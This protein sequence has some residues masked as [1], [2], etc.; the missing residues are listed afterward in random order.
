MSDVV[1]KDGD[2]WDEEW[3]AAPPTR[4]RWRTALLLTLAASLV[5]LAGVEVQRHFGTAGA[6]SS[7]AGAPT[8]A[9]PGM[10]S[11]AM[12]SGAPGQDPTGA[13]PASTQ[14]IGTVVA[15]HGSVWVVKDL[16]GTRH[17]ITVT[18]DTDI[19]REQRLTGSAVRTG[20]TVDITITS[21]GSDG[22]A[23]GTADS[24]TIR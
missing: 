17:R 8:G 10:P 4:S 13:A 7:S 18:S 2:T 12:P 21:D 15:K 1:M 19:V 9:F 11:G 14:V 22:S 6:A 24:V 20:S 23:S 3:L 16:G 5:F